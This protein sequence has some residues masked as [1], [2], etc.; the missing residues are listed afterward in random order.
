MLS[1][2]PLY[3]FSSLINDQ[4][5][6]G[7]WIHFW[8]FNSIPL[9]YLSVIV[10]VPCSFLSHSVVHLNTR[11]GDS[12]VL[13]LLRIVFAILAFFIIPD[14]FTNCPFYLSEELSWNFD[15][16]CIESVDCFQQD[17]HFYYI[18]PAN[19]LTWEIFPPSE[20]FFNFFLQRLKVLII[21][22]SHFLS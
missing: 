20:I 1:F 21:Q 6:I 15:G 5:T 12:M 18:N 7:V 13:L 3:G 10:P 22:I 17:S 11:H 16:D 14:E 19:P 2:F 9:I 4:V 8:V